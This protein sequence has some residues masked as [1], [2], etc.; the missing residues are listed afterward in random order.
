VV[1]GGLA[2]VKGVGVS[3]VKEGKICRWNGTRPDRHAQRQWPA[4]AKQGFPDRALDSTPF[5]PQALAYQEM[6]RTRHTWYARQ[7]VSQP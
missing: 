5:A 2:A 6:G 1:R 4:V 3:A 7:E